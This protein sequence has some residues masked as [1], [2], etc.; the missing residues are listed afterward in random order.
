VRPS[1]ENDTFYKCVTVL[2][3][4]CFGKPDLLDAIIGLINRI[5]V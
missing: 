1:S 2:V 5:L 3:L 4:F